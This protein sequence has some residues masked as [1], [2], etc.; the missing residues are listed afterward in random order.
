MWQYL[1]QNETAAFRIVIENLQTILR[2][3]SGKQNNI[4]Y[5]NKKHRWSMDTEH[6]ITISAPDNS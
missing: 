5:N 2:P 3:P 6:W 4:D 1:F